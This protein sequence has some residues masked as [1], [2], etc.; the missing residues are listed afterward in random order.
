M[1]RTPTACLLSL[2]RSLAMDFSNLVFELNGNPVQ[3]NH[4]HI[5]DEGS[6]YNSEATL[7]SHLL[8]DI[9]TFKHVEQSETF[10]FVS[11]STNRDE[12]DHSVALFPW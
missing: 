12:R 6:I 1:Q 11:L 3:V 7:A 8:D 10:H 5:N 4:V 9:P 2:I